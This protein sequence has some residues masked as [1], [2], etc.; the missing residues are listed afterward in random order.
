MLQ[1]PSVRG[2]LESRARRALPAVKAVA[3]SVGA[4]QFADALR[5]ETGT[6][7]G[8]KAEGGLKRPYARVIAEITPEMK[9]A[10]GRTKLTRRQILRRGMLNG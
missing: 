8:T 7:P 2:A 1:L 6:R 3:L 5:V 4:R 9:R 10:D